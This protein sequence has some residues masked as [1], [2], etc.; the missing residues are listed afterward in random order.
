MDWRQVDPRSP[1]TFFSNLFLLLRTLA[2]PQIGEETSANLDSILR[3][4]GIDVDAV[5]SLIHWSYDS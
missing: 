2:I 3:G 4:A 1:P 5:G